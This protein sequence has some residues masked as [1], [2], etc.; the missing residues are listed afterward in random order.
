LVEPAVLETIHPI[1]DAGGTIARALALDAAR[2]CRVDAILAC[3][4]APGGMF[5]AELID[6]DT[7]DVLAT[8]SAKDP[9]ELTAKIAPH[10]EPVEVILARQWWGEG[11]ASVAAG[12]ALARQGD[13]I[14]AVEKWEEAKKANPANHAA[15]HNLALA[16]EARQNYREAFTLLDQALE[17]FPLNLYHQTRKAMEQ[18]QTTFLAAAKQVE[19]IRAAALAHSAPPGKSPVIPAGYQTAPEVAPQ[20]AAHQ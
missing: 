9:H 16:A 14:A 7:G 4:A 10:Y 8:S 6:A 15:L 20:P 17:Q 3:E 18:R 13:W 5:R 11:K 2:Q 1:K 19:A 12:N